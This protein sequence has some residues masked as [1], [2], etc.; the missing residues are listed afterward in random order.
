MTNLANGKISVDYLQNGK[1]HTW[2]GDKVICTVPLGVLQKDEDE[3]GIAFYPKLSE[4]KREAIDSLA[5]KN[6]RKLSFTFSKEA[7]KEADISSK[8]L[9]FTDDGRSD[10]FDNINM[11]SGNKGALNPTLIASFVGDAAFKCDEDYKEGD[12]SLKKQM[13][14]VLTKYYPSLNMKSLVEYHD[15]AWGQDKLTYGSGAYAPTVDGY[16]HFYEMINTEYAGKLLFAGEHTNP[17][18]DDSLHGAYLSGQ[19]AAFQVMTDQPSE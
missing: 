8:K 3:G 18:S 4:S 6:I 7:F 19:R 15:K 13:L 12:E 10:I 2:T 16:K 1:I 5:M 9:I 17:S 14:A 11:L